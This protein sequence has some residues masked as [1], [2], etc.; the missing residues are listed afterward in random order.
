MKKEI[1]GILLYGFGGHARSVADVALKN[2]IPSLIFYDE[3]AQQNEAFLGF[4]VLPELPLVLP[5][6]WFAFPASGDAKCRQSQFEDI[7]KR[8]WP[9]NNII[10]STATIGVLSE[11]GV[12]IFVGHHAHI[13][14]KA[15]IG[16]GCIINTAALIEHDCRI[17]NFTH[18]SVNCTIAG[19]TTIGNCCFLGASSTAIDSITIG[20]NITLGAGGCFISDTPESGVYVGTPAKRIK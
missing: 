8:G 2:G 5:E 1:K 6:G 18:I 19:N 4:A 7:N 12:G 10:S 16:N 20:S 3:N 14:P 17:G 13:G 11:I 9:V 15:Q